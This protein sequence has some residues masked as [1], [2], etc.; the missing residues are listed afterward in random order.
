MRLQ[1]FTCHSV[2]NLLIIALVTIPMV[3]V[4]ESGCNTISRAIARRNIGLKDYEYHLAPLTENQT[5]LLNKEFSE[6]SRHTGKTLKARN[7]HGPYEGT[8]KP[9]ALLVNHLLKLKRISIITA[10]AQEMDRTGHTATPDEIKEALFSSSVAFVPNRAERK[11]SEWTVAVTGQTKA[12]KAIRV[13]LGFDY[14]NCGLK[15]VTRYEE[16]RPRLRPTTPRY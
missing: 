2:K 9:V 16:E 5:D 3:V 10:H 4:G 8:P 11:N 12:G 13:V 7:T 6:V 1:S 15:V 14:K